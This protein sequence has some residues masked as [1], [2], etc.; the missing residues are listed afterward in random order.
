MQIQ[1]L[2][3]LHL[4][5]ERSYKGPGKEL[6]HFEFPKNAECLA[7]LGDTGCT[8]HEELFDW[9]RGQME[10]FETILF[11]AGNHGKYIQLFSHII[12]SLTH[13]RHRTLRMDCSKQQ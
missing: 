5:I 7:L 8:A 13:M 6:Y 2:S 1:L 3:D 9:L 11:V 12:R 10:R 4:E